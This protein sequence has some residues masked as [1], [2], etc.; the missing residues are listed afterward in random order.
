[1][2]LRDSQLGFCHFRVNFKRG[3]ECSNFSQLL[4]WVGRVRPDIGENS[5]MAKA[6]GEGVVR[7]KREKVSEG[8]FRQ[9][10]LLGSWAVQLLWW[11][12]KCFVK[13]CQHFLGFCFADQGEKEQQ[14]LGFLF[15][16][17]GLIL[18]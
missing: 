2:K 12:S 3:R 13:Y 15:W 16:I 7:V 1:M 14:F 18:E 17:F 10:A 4:K 9:F 11:V 8:F 5:S 6:H